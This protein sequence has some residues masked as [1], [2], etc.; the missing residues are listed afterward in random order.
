MEQK[1]KANTRIYMKKILY[2]PNAQEHEDYKNDPVRLKLLCYQIFEEIR[3]DF[4]YL[5]FNEFCLYTALY[6]FIKYNDM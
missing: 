3:S 5:G 6:L 4:Y 2:L 1:E